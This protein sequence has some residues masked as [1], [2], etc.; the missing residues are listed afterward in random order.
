MTSLSVA[1]AQPGS[2]PPPGTPCC[3][4]G[5]PV[6]VNVT[7][8]G[9]VNCGVAC[10]PLT[11]TFDCP[12]DLVDC[13]GDLQFVVGDFTSGGPDTA[14]IQLAEGV[15][16]IAAS[17]KAGIRCYSSLCGCFP[18]SQ[19]STACP[20]TCHQQDGFP[21]SGVVIPPNRIWV[22]PNTPGPGQTQIQINTH[23]APDGQLNTVELSLCVSDEAAALCP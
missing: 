17:V 23:A 8:Q 7:E 11:F 19:T 6:T 5:T 16:L 12:P 10:M 18:P 3:P 20:N 22:L 4:S 21:C 1:R 15:T 14:I 9:G 2:P 13:L